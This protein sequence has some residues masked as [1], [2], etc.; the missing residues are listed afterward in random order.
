M[1]H[2]HLLS[3]QEKERDIPTLPPANRSFLLA[4]FPRPS[5]F[6]SSQ[7]DFNLKVLTIPGFDSRYDWNF[8]RSVCP[9][10]DE[11]MLVFFLLLLF[12]YIEEVKKPLLVD[13]LSRNFRKVSSS[14]K[15][16]RN[17]KL[18]IHRSLFESD[19]K[20]ILKFARY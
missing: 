13:V 2:L 18:K 14:E 20:R 12:G 5:H 4:S 19:F 16:P 10:T 11:P 7:Y 15:L 9:L 6:P 1:P 8:S 3:P 17:W